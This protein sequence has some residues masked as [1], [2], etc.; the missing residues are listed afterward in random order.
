MSSEKINIIVVAFNRPSSLNRLLKSLNNA[1]YHNDTVRLIISV[2]GGKDKKN[3]KV[4][5]IANN[6]VW[7]YG[8]KIVITHKNNLGLKKHILKCGDLS[9]KYGDIIMLEDDLF[10]SCEFY[11]FAKNSLNFFAKNSKIAGISLYS[12]NYNE[13]A[14]KKFVP[15]KFKGE[16][17]FL[18][19]ASSWGQ[20][21]TT[22]QWNDFKSWY[23]M[24][25]EDDFSSENIPQNIKN[26]PNS[27]WKKYFIKYMIEKD[28]YFVYPYT[29]YVTNMGEIGTNNTQ[30]TNTL[31]VPIQLNKITK[32]DFIKF[33]ESKSI[34]D[35]FHENV[36]LKDKLETK[37]KGKCIVDIYGEKKLNSD[38]DYVLT[39]KTLPKKILDEYSLEMY[40]HDQNIFLDI[41]GKGIFL[42]DMKS[43]NHN[44]KTNR[45]FYNYK[46]IN[47]YYFKEPISLKKIFYYLLIELYF[48]LF[49]N[50]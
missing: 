18:Q 50:S 16:N 8:E 11:F 30:K 2:D 44:Y 10:V 5:S 46:K 27:S 21:W 35:S 26:W 40:P 20:A 12:Q 43:D 28:K 3:K 49:K 24:K 23:L 22:E 31:Q 37:Y 36:Y 4:I 32:I 45:M 7:N 29:S 34:Y 25:K 42:Y 1:N 17:Y 6:F 48:R 33:K 39:T 14:N 41:K 19:L 9:K 15:L 47:Y 13:T 38:I